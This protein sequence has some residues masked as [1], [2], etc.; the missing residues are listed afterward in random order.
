MAIE[1]FQGGCAPTEANGKRERA[2]LARSAL[3]VEAA[4]HQLDQL[5][6]YRQTKPRAP[7]A[8]R[9]R[10]V[11]LTERLEQV[12]QLVRGDSYA[13]VPNRKANSRAVLSRLVQADINGHLAG[14]REL[15]GIGY[16]VDQ[17]LL[18]PDGVADQKV[19]HV[20]RAVDNQLQELQPGHRGD[21]LNDLAPHVVCTRKNTLLSPVQAVRAT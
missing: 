19:R 5:A 20:G 10:L 3:N 2:A 1:G 15:D 11:S 7:E 14:G 4:T 6:A 17:H 13:A 9:H 12:P 8:P 18:E 21:D 16:Q